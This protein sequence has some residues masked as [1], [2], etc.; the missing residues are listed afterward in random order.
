MRC[1]LQGK[2]IIVKGNPGN[3][4]SY[5][6]PTDAVKQILMQSLIATPNFSQIGST[7]AM[8]ILNVAQ[9]VAKEFGVGVEI[10][11]SQISRKDNYV[12]Q[13]VPTMLETDFSYGIAQWAKWF[14]SKFRD[15]LI[16]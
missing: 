16:G 15:Y 11:D 2:P 9:L 3:L 14:K 12:P 6:Y 1:G 10:L 13:D 5:L 7:K 8:T 4:R